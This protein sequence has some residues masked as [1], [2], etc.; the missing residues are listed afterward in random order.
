MRPP[1][2]SS[3][4][5]T[6]LYTPAEVYDEMMISKNRRGSLT[7]PKPFGSR[8]SFQRR[9]LQ[10]FSSAITRTVEEELEISRRQA[11]FSLS[12]FSRSQH[13]LNSSLSSESEPVSSEFT[14]TN[15]DEW[16]Q[17]SYVLLQSQGHFIHPQVIQD[18]QKV[19]N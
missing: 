1:K 17:V 16:K 18:V 19:N 12:S 2:K 15:N 10:N 5:R 13:I 8:E 9:S 11:E 6:N 3:A 7:F 4:S 14:D